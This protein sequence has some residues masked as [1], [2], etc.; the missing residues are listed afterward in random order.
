MA[1][2]RMSKPDKQQIVHQKMVEIVGDEDEKVRKA[3]Q[4]HIK[5][6][7]GS[8]IE[9]WKAANE[10]VERYEKELSAAVVSTESE[11]PTGVTICDRNSASWPG[12]YGSTNKVQTPKDL[13]VHRFESEHIGSQGQDFYDSR[14]ILQVVLKYRHHKNARIAGACEEGLKILVNGDISAVEEFLSL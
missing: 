8:V 6:V 9:A 4:G 11:L 1:I 2:A 5:Y 10:A 14:Q 7:T 12:Q 3:K 13:L